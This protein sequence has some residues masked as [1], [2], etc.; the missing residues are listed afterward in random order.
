MFW[1][2][3]KR[4]HKNKINLLRSLFQERHLSVLSWMD[5]WDRNF[6]KR[7]QDELF[8]LATTKNRAQSNKKPV[9]PIWDFFIIIQFTVDWKTFYFFSP[10]Y[11]YFPLIFI[12][13]DTSSAFLFIQY[14]SFTKNHKETLCKQNLWEESQHN[15]SEYIS[16]DHNALTQIK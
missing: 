9:V 14:P 2:I 11:L 6:R 5:I 8:P 4:N 15:T 10:H 16:Y 1:L 13:A 12:H 3:T 7:D